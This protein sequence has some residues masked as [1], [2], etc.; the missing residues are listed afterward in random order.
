MGALEE[1]DL[2]NY[3]YPHDKE[4]EA[5][6]IRGLYLN[7]YL[8]WDS[9]SQHE[10]MIRSYG[11][12]TEKQLR[13]F[14]TYNDVDCFHYSGL[15]D[16]IKFLK[17]GYSKVTDHASR[18]IRLKRLT[19]YDGIKLI[20][21]YS[22]IMPKDKNLFLD[23]LGID[24]KELIKNVNKFRSKDIWEKNNNKWNLKDEIF[25]NKN[26][27]PLGS[28]SLNKVEK[29]I[30]NSNSKRFNENEIGKYTLIGKGYFK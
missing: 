1:R 2:Q 27:H 24:F 29:C 20:K 18:E 10:K 9:K 12:E 19:R 8:R 23:W 7:N 6:G 5:V 14:D 13:T 21:R 3:L 30:F 17:Y 4:I 16:Y 28:N 25:N 22:N 15:H 11:Y 26:S